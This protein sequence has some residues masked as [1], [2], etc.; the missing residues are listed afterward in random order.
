[1]N[2]QMNNIL[3]LCVLVMLSFEVDGGA[4][5]QGCKDVLS[6]NSCAT[7]PYVC[8]ISRNKRRRCFIQRTQRN[9]II[10]KV[11]RGC[12]Y[13]CRTGVPIPIGP[14]ISIKELLPLLDWL[15]S[16]SVPAYQVGRLPFP[17]ALVAMPKM[18]PSPLPKMYIPKSVP[19]TDNLEQITIEQQA[20]RILQRHLFG[21]I[22]PTVSAC[23]SL[24]NSGGFIS[25]G[26]SVQ[27]WSSLL[28]LKTYK[29]IVL[30]SM[31]P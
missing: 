7:K 23:F 6:D 20:S 15:H 10:L 19:L 27:L 11:T 21:G 9:G 25:S 5:C 29:T 17:Q 16:C 4:Y 3:L 14:H 30:F 26:V 31:V 1:M 28:I 12:S 2:I 22:Q 18:S 8:K 13:S 24:T